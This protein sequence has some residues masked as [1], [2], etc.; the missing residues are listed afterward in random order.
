LRGAL[1]PQLVERAIELSEKRYC[2]VSASLR[3]KVEITT[4]YEIH[5]GD[6]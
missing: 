1:T 5:Q 2:A 6:E 3:P 4:S